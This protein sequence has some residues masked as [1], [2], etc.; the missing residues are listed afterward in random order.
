LYLSRW[1]LFVLITV[2]LSGEIEGFVLLALLNRFDLC[3][4][5]SFGCN[6]FENTGSSNCLILVFNNSGLIIL[7]LSRWLLFVLITVL[8]SGEIE[9][10][11]LLA[12]LDRFDLCDEA[13]FGCNIFENTGSSN[14]LILVFNNSGLII[15][16]LS[17]WLLFVL[18][19]V[20][21]SGEIEGFVLLALLNRFDLCDEAS[22]GCNIFENTGSSNCLILV[23]NNSGLIILYLSRWLLFVLITVLLS[24]EI[25][26]FVLLA[27]LDRFDLCDEASFG[28]NIFENTGSSNCLILVFNNSGLI[29]LYLSRWLLFVLITVLLSGEIEG[30][31]LLALLNR[32]DLCD[33]A[34]FGCN[35]FENT[36]SSNCLILVFNNSG[37]IILYLSRWLLFVLITVLLSGEIEGFVLLALLDRFDLCDEASFGCNIFENTGSSNCLILV[38]NNSGLIILYLSRWLLF[39]LITVLLSGE[40]EGFVLLALLD[41]FD[42]CDEASFGC[43]IFEN[44]GSSNLIIIGFQY[45]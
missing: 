9:G 33:E 25:E 22:F 32:F 3:D 13:S 7:Y 34:S 19:T 24:G 28:C 38:F 29:I 27:L 41:R 40:I 1:L 44:T 20:L 42:L 14:C 18:I 35:I 10:F 2:L 11:V 8:L 45:I 15:L 37:L 43:N 16:Y 31:V 12:L 17:R 26:G 30:F 6:I 21:L 5:A 23:F 39:V 4:E 36:G